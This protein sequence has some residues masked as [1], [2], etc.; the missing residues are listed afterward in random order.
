M[1]VIKLFDLE[2]YLFNQKRLWALTALNANDA[3]LG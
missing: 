2:K 1:E 3:P